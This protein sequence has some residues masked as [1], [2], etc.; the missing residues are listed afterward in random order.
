[1]IR[2]PP[3]S[4]RTDT[5]FPYTTLFRSAQR[6]PQPRSPAAPTAAQPDYPAQLISPHH[7]DFRAT[8]QEEPPTTPTTHPPNTADE[9]PRQTSVHTISKNSPF[10]LYCWERDATLAG[11]AAQPKRTRG[12]PPPNA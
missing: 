7:R 5:L 6:H 12:S 11:Y 4:T 2:R 1:M 9:T 3:R 10:F 8:R